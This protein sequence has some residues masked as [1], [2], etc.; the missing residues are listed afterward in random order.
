MSGERLVWGFIDLGCRPNGLLFVVVGG[1]TTFS[2]SGDPLVF[3]E[4]VEKER[5]RRFND[6][7]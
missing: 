2:L 3:G 5:A 6:R 4:G 7:E 1:G